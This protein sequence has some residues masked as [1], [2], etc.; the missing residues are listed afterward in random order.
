MFAE[1]QSWGPK[2]LRPWNNIN[3]IELNKLSKNLHEKNKQ[4][5][6]RSSPKNLAPNIYVHFLPYL[7]LDIAPLFS[8][9][10]LTCF[11]A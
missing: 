5:I 1:R 3:L 7:N 4:M 9:K 8:W 6:D 10:V 2:K 11:E